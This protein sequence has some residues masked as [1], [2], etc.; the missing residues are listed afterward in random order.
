M[1]AYHGGDNPVTVPSSWQDWQRWVQDVDWSDWRSWLQRVAST[2][3]TAGAW[4]AAPWEQASRPREVSLTFQAFGEHEPG[5][6]IGEH[7]AVTWPA[8]GDG[9][10]RV[11]TPARR[12]RWPGR[13]SK[14]TCPNSSPRGSGWPPCSEMIPMR[15]PR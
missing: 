8:S 5:D 1:T 15:P 13:G 10:V 2:D 7:L 4:P 12:P 9:G 14:S 6:Q 3:W 11:R